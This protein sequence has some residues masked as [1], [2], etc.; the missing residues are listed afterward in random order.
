MAKSPS[1]GVF[2]TST[3]AFPK[4]FSIS[5]F[6][7][8][9]GGPSSSASTVSTSSTGGPKKTKRK[10]EDDEMEVLSSGGEDEEGFKV[11]KVPAKLKSRGSTDGRKKGKKDKQPEVLDLTS[12]D[13][14]APAT[15]SS[16]PPSPPKK[17]SSGKK[18]A[19]PKGKG[20]GKAKAA[21]ED[22]DISPLA[23]QH[24][25]E[26]M[27]VDQYAPR[28]RD[29]LAL[30]P[31]KLHDVETWLC[32]A[33][34]V[35]PPPS[36]SKK[37]A[38]PPPPN[39]KLAKYRRV[40]VLSG[41]AGSAKTAALKVL[42]Q[43][44]GVG[45]VEWAEGMRDEGGGDEPRESLIHRFSSFLAVAGMAPALD[46]GSFE[47]SA[48]QPSSSSS[49]PVASSSCASASAPHSALPAGKRLILLEDLPN[50]SHYPTKLALRSAVSQYLSSPR[51]T[52]P[53]VIVISEALARP[54]TDAGGGIALGSMGL[55]RGDSLDARSVLGVEILQHPAC[56]E[57]ARTATATPPLHLLSF[58]PI[59]PTILRKTL[60]RTLD[61]IFAPVSS[62]ASSGSK[63]RRPASSHATRKVSRLPPSS[64]PTL[65]SLDQLIAHSNGDI[66]SALMSLEFL[67]KQGGDATAF[68][69]SGAGGKKGGAKKVK[70]RKRKGSDDESSEEEMQGKGKGKSGQLLSFVTARESSLFIFHALGKVLYNKRWGNS[71]E[72]DKKDLNRPGIVQ[73]RAFDELPKH[74]RE[75]WERKVSK[76]DVDL[77]FAEAP[78]DPEIFLSYLHHNYPPFTTDISQ[79]AGVLEGLS[80]GDAL[81]GVRGEGEEAY[82]H[83]TLTSHYAFNLSVRQTLLSLPSPVPKGKQ[84]LRKSEL[85]ETLRLA[86]ANEEGVAELLGSSARG[87]RGLL[88]ASNAGEMDEGLKTRRESASLMSEVVPWLGV[89]QPKDANPFLLDLATFPPLSS[90]SQPLVTGAALGEKDLE[91]EDAD[92]EDAQQQPPE[93]T[94]TGKLGR[95]L[96][97]IEEEDEGEREE[98]VDGEVLFD[99]SDDI[100]D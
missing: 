40:L 67:A 30:H 9:L 35:P 1:K 66:R 17:M 49:P 21:E 28:D 68:G 45:I 7:P 47:E 85:W 62:S 43:E 59:A 20:K 31:R 77:L 88:Y 61:R 95:V 100:I 14:L 50:V 87:S 94:Q 22:G 72:D 13:E 73:D 36:T 19:A 46:F 42:C 25:S 32:E 53:L 16:S 69:D 4:Q 52:C 93:P 65:A 84:I 55:N 12:D 57:I 15:S 56:R 97:E 98:K 83:R 33:F 38:P 81:M 75:E 60:Q 80:A 90:A 92:G 18:P 2:K 78:L 64:R 79:C 86:R 89:I 27:W 51:V 24:Y 54:G 23:Q 5:S 76:V 99:E 41:A 58:N 3:T 34:C 96:Q 6:L 11:P 29:D 26:A 71:A 44:M 82:R 48:A 39:P 91:D 8:K 10:A 70:K 37:A 74:L 63:S